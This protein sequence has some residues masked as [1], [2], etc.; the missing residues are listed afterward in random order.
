MDLLNTATGKNVVELVEQKLL[1]Q[2]TE[3]V[4]SGLGRL[5]TLAYFGTRG[6]TLMSIV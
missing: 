3:N 1:P 6:H 5:N 4:S 2:R